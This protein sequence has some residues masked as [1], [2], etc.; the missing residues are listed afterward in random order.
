MLNDGVLTQLG[1]T[2]FSINNP[3]GYA[4]PRTPEDPV[5][6]ELL[7]SPNQNNDLTNDWP[8]KAAFDEMW[9]DGRFYATKGA[10]ATMPCMTGSR[11]S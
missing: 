1:A 10:S 2:Q 8:Y 7:N 5:S 11:W 4:G 6:E 9:E 3:I